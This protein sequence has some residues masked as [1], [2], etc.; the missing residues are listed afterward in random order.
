MG[1]ASYSWAASFSTI[2]TVAA[3]PVVFYMMPFW[4]YWM[5][6]IPM[7]CA[8]KARDPPHGDNS[9]VFGWSGR[10]LSN[11]F[12]VRAFTE[13][14]NLLVGVPI[15]GVARGRVCASAAAAMHPSCGRPRAREKWPATS[16]PARSRSI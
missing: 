10:I 2:M 9:E 13:I 7:A 8:S 6:P 14:A 1:R 4:M 11:P 3:G 16:G 5:R 15:C 12:Q